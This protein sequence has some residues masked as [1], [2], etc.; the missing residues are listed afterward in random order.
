MTLRGLFFALAVLAAFLLVFVPLARYLMGS[1][2][3]RIDADRMRRVYMAL[4]LYEMSNG[5]LPAPNLGLVRQ[6]VE[7]IDLQSVDD[8]NTG[9]QAG[10]FPLDPALP[11]LPLKSPT[12][13]SWSY[14]WHWPNAGDPVAVRMDPRKGLL[15]S[16][17]SGP[18]LRVNVA[19]ALTQTPRTD[20][21]RL[22]FGDL[23]GK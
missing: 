3:Q 6:D 13:V 17:W 2:E 23:F 4:S 19:G 20:T 18:V 5:G 8:P 15:A 7:A 12:R 1:T 22:S 16:W 14:R 9:G 11:N 21:S 10:P